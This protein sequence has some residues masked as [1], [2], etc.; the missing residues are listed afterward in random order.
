METLKLIMF[1]P[2]LEASPITTPT[3]ADETTTTYA[4]SAKQVPSTGVSSTTSTDSTRSSSEGPAANEGEYQT[5][6]RMTRWL[7]IKPARG[8]Q[9]RGIMVVQRDKE[10]LYKV[11][12][13]MQSTEHPGGPYSLWVIQE[14]VTHPLCVSGRDIGKYWDFFFWGGG[15][16]QDIPFCVKGRLG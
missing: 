13:H 7:I 9:Q 4:A 3:T 14:F 16:M 15:G 12:K 5:R 11:V 6:L 10:N 8:Q 1:A 2:P